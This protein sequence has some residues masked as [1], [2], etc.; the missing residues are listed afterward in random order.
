MKKNIFLSMVLTLLWTSLSPAQEDTNGNAVQKEYYP[1]GKIKSE[2]LYKNG[3]ENTRKTYYPNG[4]LQTESVFLFDEE[5][6]Y[7]QEV[8]HKAYDETG[9]LIT[10]GVL[11]EY[12]EGTHQ[13]AKEITYKNGRPNGEARFFDESGDLRCQAVYR[14]GVEIIRQDFTKIESATGQTPAPVKNKTMGS[15]LVSP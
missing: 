8:S 12:F 9:G 5:L 10:D 1:S 2:A 11:R 6:R 3:Y 13:L 14:D 15:A 7:S 4:R